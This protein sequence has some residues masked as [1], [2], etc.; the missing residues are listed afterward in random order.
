MRSL[1]QLLTTQHRMNPKEHD[2][3]GVVASMKRWGFT[4]PVTLDETSGVLVAGHGR[5]TALARMRDAGEQPPARVTTELG[6][7]MVPTL[8]IAFADDEERDAYVIADNKLTEAGGW[9]NAKLAQMMAGF[10]R[11][12]V[13]SMGFTKRAYDSLL[14]RFRPAQKSDDVDVAPPREPTV[15]YGQVWELGDHTLFCNDCTTVS[16]ERLV[17]TGRG[18]AFTSPP[19]NASPPGAGTFSFDG[20]KQAREKYEGETDD[21]LSEPQYLALLRESLRVQLIACEVAC[22]NLQMLESNKRPIARWI[23]E[24]ADNLVD[25]L[26]WDKGHARPAMWPGVLN[27]GHEDLWVFSRDT[28]PNRRIATGDFHG[29]VGNVHRGGANID[30]EYAGQHAGTMPKHLAEFVIG[31]L[32]FKAEYIVDVFAGTGTTLMVAHQFG[33]RCI[34]VERSPAYCDIILERWKKLTGLSAMLAQDV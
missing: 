27:S 34:M 11:T 23:G 13:Q 30:N 8:S 18:F 25:K 32:A 33:K 12:N 7:W 14:A 26:V 1:D 20:G 31:N 17:S 3:D 19:Y 2:T 24:H 16:A 4:V 10:K 5:L 21:R 29:N 22:V 28:T 6:D 15:K 9:D